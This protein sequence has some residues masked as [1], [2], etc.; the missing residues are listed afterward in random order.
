MNKKALLLAACF[1]A[2]STAACFAGGKGLVATV[3]GDKIT[4]NDLTKRLWWYSASKGLNELIDET[5]LLQEAGKL[6]VKADEKEVK[7]RLN[8]IKSGKDSKEFE[9]NLESINW[10]EKDLA[11]LIRNQLTIRD[12]VVKKGGIEVTDEMA[13]DYYDKNTE[14]FRTPESAKLLQIFVSD[15]AKADTAYAALEAGAD[16]AIMSE[17]QS[18]DPG[19]REN[20]GNLGFINKSMLQPDLAKEVFALKA[21]EYTKPIPTGNGFSII[22][23]EEY[24]A[25]EKIEYENAK[26]DLKAAMK[27]QMINDYL[28]RL[29]A[30]LKAD[31]KIELEK[32]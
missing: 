26:E 30:E 2:V 9:K 28:P 13:K 7:E 20:K 12:T 4:E 29:V 16:F 23:M 14:R 10:S 3:N 19:L 8:E 21:G 1:T 11:G 15:K 27:N 31:A 22:K 24:K 32:K 6:K 5:L 17:K 25:S 18:D